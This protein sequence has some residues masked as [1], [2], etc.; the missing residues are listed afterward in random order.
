MTKRPKRPRDPAQLVVDIAT[1]EI[2]E[3][4]SLPSPLKSLHAADELLFKEARKSRLFGRPLR[5]V[6]QFLS[7]P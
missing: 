5:H 7:H 6:L 2:E 1:G 3:K 4:T